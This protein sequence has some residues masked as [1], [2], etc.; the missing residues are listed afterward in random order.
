MAVALLVLI[1]VLVIVVV[2]AGHRRSATKG[3]AP[4]PSPSAA[5]SP[6]G[7]QPPQVQLTDRGAALLVSW[8]APAEGAGP[9][10]VAL[11]RAGADATVVATL[12]PETHEYQIEHLDPQVDYCV[13]VAAVYSGEPAS[14][15]TTACTRRTTTGD[16]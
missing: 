4:A 1:A 8:T 9:T 15:A 16:R 3:A 13:I 2:K 11:S 6:T 12:P 7:H 14:A 10:V 5:P